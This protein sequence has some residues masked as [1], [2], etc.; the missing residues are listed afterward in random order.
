MPTCIKDTKSSMILYADD[1]ILMTSGT[2][3]E[4]VKCTLTS[5]LSKCHHWLSNNKLVIHSGKTETILL[6]SRRKK[7]L[8]SN[9][10][11]ITREM[12]LNHQKILGILG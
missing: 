4:E 8:I 9:L 11:S 12:K 6:T 2:D 5:A 10:Y 1:A 7:H 3:I